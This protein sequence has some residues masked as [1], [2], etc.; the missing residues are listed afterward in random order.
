MH[1]TTGTWFTRPTKHK[2]L[3]SHVSLNILKRSGV[4]NKEGVT[5]A[6]E[7]LHSR[8]KLRDQRV[9]QGM[10]IR[11]LVLDCSSSHGTHPRDLPLNPK[12]S[13]ALLEGKTYC[14]KLASIGGMT[15]VIKPVSGRV[16]P[17]ST[18]T[19]PRP[20][21]DLSNRNINDIKTVV[22]HSFMI[23]TRRETGP[24]RR[25]SR[26]LLPHMWPSESIAQAH[27]IQSF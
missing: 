23:R 1:R 18:F 2:S 6:G 15:T 26:A 13:Q 14:V 7:L 17:A 25:V 12:L 22:T 4:E 11:S 8:I 20:R 19:P 21:P 16:V 24:F 5:L 27:N 9:V 10:L 3:M